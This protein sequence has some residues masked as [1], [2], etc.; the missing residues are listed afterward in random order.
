MSFSTQVFSQA[1]DQTGSNNTS[2]GQAGATGSSSTAGREAGSAE[3]G[4][5]AQDVGGVQQLFARATDA[6]VSEDG[7]SQLQQMFASRERMQG[8]ESKGEARGGLSGSN[9]D[10]SRTSGQTSGSSVRSDSAGV[11][12]SERSGRDTSETGSPRTNGT[13]AQAA[14]N[15]QAQQQLNQIVQQI[16]Q[17]W[18]Q[19][20]NQDFKITNESVVFSD[21]TAADI[22]MR[23]ARPAAGE[24]R[25][26][27]RGAAGESR[28]LG[29]DQRGTGAAN[30]SSD[31]SS[32]YSRNDR[33][34][35][36]ASGSAAS[37]ANESA[38]HAGEHG[39]ARPIT[40]NVPAVRG[41]EAVQVRL[42]REGEQFKFASHG[43]IEQQKLAES[44]EKHLREVQ[45]S[46]KDWPADVN[47]GFRLVTQHVLMAINDA[48]GRRG[49]SGD[50]AQ[51][52]G[53][54]IRGTDSGTSGTSGT[55]GSSSSG[56]GSNSGS[57]GTGSNQTR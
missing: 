35:S 27:Q 8:H 37:E 9:S 45:E 12:G 29:G 44:L 1:Q 11:A 14:N 49:E 15:A 25:G 13:G 42:I 22:G 5:H 54:R 55:S 7:L 17:E 51:P 39:M 4:K 24:L 20:Y 52:A 53:S 30:S 50:N 6:A 26:T 33:T 18:K 40:V 41:T 10:Q 16:R 21:I 32:T 28:D 43:Q 23:E 36:S 48:T 3:S 56:A 46:Q 38:E 31:R 57:T 2:A 19:K 34:S 47:Q